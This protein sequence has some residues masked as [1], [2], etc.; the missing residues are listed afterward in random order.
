MTYE[1]M[2]GY[3]KHGNARPGTPLEGPL[4]GVAHDIGNG[5]STA[6]QNMLYFNNHQPNASAHVFIDDKEIL[7]IIP[8][9]EKA[10]HVQYQKPYDNL[11]FGEDANDAAIG[12]E[13][14]WGGGINFIEAY[15]RYVWFW[16]WLCRKYNWD[17]HEKIASHKQLDPERRTDPDNALNKHGITYSQFLNDVKEEI[18]K[19]ALA[20]EPKKEKQVY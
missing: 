4:F 2:H 14:C 16:A 6:R 18:Y 11:R 13:L 3:I 5:G 1:I 9:N 8:L 19:M 7:V 10:Y 20:T 15:K 17:P 12:V